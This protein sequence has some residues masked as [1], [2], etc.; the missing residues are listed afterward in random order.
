MEAAVA[1]FRCSASNFHV[2]PPELDARVTPEEVAVAAA[3]GL[4][5][6]RAPSPLDAL[7]NELL[8]YGG[9]GM[10]A[11]LATFFDFQ[12]EVENKAQTPG[13]IRSLHKRG[14]ATLP[15]NYR[16]ITLG[17]SIDKLYNLVLHRRLMTYLEGTGGLHEA[18]NGFRHGRSAADNLHILQK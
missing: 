17:A 15:D 7:P 5:D 4:H 11:A 9:P 14:D 6:D 8:K 1:A 18:Q 10:H 3:A 2:G 16:P 13:V 12:W